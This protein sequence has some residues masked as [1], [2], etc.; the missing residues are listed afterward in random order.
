MGLE[1]LQSLRR[2]GDG[3][4]VLGDSTGVRNCQARAVRTECGF[5]LRPPFKLR[6]FKSPWASSGGTMG[7]GKLEVP[8]PLPDRN[9]D[10]EIRQAQWRR[11][12]R[13]AVEFDRNRAEFGQS[14]RAFGQR[15]S[16]LGRVRS[17][18]A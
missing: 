16:K 11:M 18:L 8:S 2:H 12:H 7:G 4:G 14:W 15:G 13:T 6:G 17:T 10:L 9:W 3:I 1:S 5:K